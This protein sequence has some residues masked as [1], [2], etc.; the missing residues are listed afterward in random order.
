MF[1][2]QV[3][4]D[5]FLIVVLSDDRAGSGRRAVRW[6]NRLQRANCSLLVIWLIVLYCSIGY[7][8][9]FKSS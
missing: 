3:G 7:M 5:T 6:S 2:L 4:Y 8:I 1:D 9:I